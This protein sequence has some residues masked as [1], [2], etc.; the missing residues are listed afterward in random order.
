MRSA[1]GPV[2][3]LASHPAMRAE[4]QPLIA[5]PMLMGPLNPTQT[6]AIVVC[7]HATATVDLSVRRV[8]VRQRLDGTAVDAQTW[9]TFQ[10][11]GQVAP[12][13]EWSRRYYEPLP[14]QPPLQPGIHTLVVKA[15]VDDLNWQAFDAR[16]DEAQA[17]LL[18]RLFSRRAQRAPHPVARWWQWCELTL[19]TGDGEL[20]TIGQPL[21]AC[22]HPTA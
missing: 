6:L 15:V 9:E 20:K 14:Y 22:P 21:T 4:I 5:A 18:S 19:A 13:G 3:L 7:V 12:A 17:S 11:A 2:D 10:I 16:H 8:V 1:G